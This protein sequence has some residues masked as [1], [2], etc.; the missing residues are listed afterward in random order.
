MG[1]YGANKS[2]IF[3]APILEVKNLTIA[4]NDEKIIDNLSFDVAA[5][6]ILI[7]MGPNGAGKTVLLKSLLGLLPHK[8]EIRWQKGIKIGYAPQKLLQT[9]DV[10]LTVEDF[11]KFK[12]IDDSRIFE[13]L[14]MVGI[15]D[16]SILKERLANLSFGEL[17]RVLIGWAIAEEPQVLLFDEPTS[18]ID[19]G[20]EET[21]Y[22]LLYNLWREKG[23][24]ILLV[25]HDLS[26][27]YQYA[28]NVLCINKRKL[29]YG[30]PRQ[31]L[32]P[33]NLEKIYGVEVR[34]H[35]H[36]H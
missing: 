4:F 14:N 13:I 20:G 29:R 10:P 34:F 15:K 11:L 3:M 36:N 8:G 19:I 31:I 27:V 35:E 16:K 32:T 33:E 5:K 22:N 17:Q 9:K 25:S 12:K 24:T 28:T 23:M 2:L 18:G 26:V 30:P 21:I 1:R 7:I 6:E